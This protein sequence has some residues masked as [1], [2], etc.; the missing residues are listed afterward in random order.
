MKRLRIA[1][2]GSELAL[3]QAKF[4]ASRL[5][6]ESE[7]VVV[8][9]EGDRDLSSQLSSI[10]GQ[11]VFVKEIQAALLDG[12]ADLAVHSAKDLPT[13][14]VGGLTIAAFPKRGDVRDALVGRSLDELVP[15]STV[16]TGSLRRKVQLQA[17]RPDLKF[18][19]LRG[20]MATRISKAREYG[21]VVVA[22][23]AL[24]RLGRLDSVSQVFEPDKF[25]PQVGQ[26]SLAVECR[27]DDINIKKILN[28]LDHQS[29][30]LAVEAER[31]LLRELGS[32]CSLPLGAFATVDE[33]T[34][35][36]RL[37]AF[38]A[39][40]DASEMV[41]VSG[42]DRDHLSLGSR[43]GQELLQKGGARIL[44]QLKVEL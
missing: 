15:G 3:W 5:G 38:I 22:Y 26:G 20:N 13:L 43:L 1:T 4:V 32:G 44:D 34:G 31:S 14:S 36:V 10:G 35:E 33:M 28:R 24:E 27:I 2:R 7:I 19:S 17:M 12:R 42:S 41:F 6:C 39:A 16:A 9:T 11:G 37:H 18:A 8:N 23:A 29:T 25:I 40:L 30:R 21:A